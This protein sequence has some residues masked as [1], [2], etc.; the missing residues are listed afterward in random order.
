MSCLILNTG[1]SQDCRQ[2][3]GGIKR[4]LVAQLSSITS[5]TEASGVAT[6]IATSGLFYEFKPTKDS[7]TASAPFNGDVA[8]GQRAWT[9]TVVM[10]FSKTEAAKR[11]TVSVLAENSVVV[12]AEDNN[13]T[14][15]LYGY[16]RGLDLTE[17]D[18]TLGT[19]AADMNGYTLT[20]SGDQAYLPLQVD[21]TIIAGLLV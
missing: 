10:Q 14:Y 2:S 8:A 13:E 9:H 12:I 1:I 18:N 21:P 19:V 11:N 7:S 20:M 17:G 5:V 3:L 6:A 4:F 15:I 16:S